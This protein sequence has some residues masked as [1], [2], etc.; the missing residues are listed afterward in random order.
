MPKP[1]S[2]VCHA[3]RSHLAVTRASYVWISEDA[4]SDTFTAFVHNHKRHGSNVPG[5]LEARKRAAKRRATQLAHQPATNYNPES[6]GVFDTRSQ[7]GWWQKGEKPVEPQATSWS[8]PFIFP[9]VARGPPPPPGPMLREDT[10]ETFEAQHG[11]SN[12]VDVEAKLQSHLRSVCTHAA[13]MDTLFNLS[14][15]VR[16]NPQF[17]NIILNHMIAQHWEHDEIAEFLIDPRTNPPGTTNHIY[18]LEHAKEHIELVRWLLRENVFAK[19]ARLGLLDITEIQQMLLLMPKLDISAF[20][21]SLTWAS[22]CWRLVDAMDESMVLTVHD[23]DTS[24]IASWLETMRSYSFC[25]AVPSLQWRL[26]RLLDSKVDKALA[27]VAY[28]S[29]SMVKE[30][31]IH[32]LESLVEFM[33]SQPHEHVG[34]AIFSL[35]HK[36][37][38]EAGLDKPESLSTS[39]LE[40]HVD[41]LFRKDLLRQVRGAYDFVSL[42]VDG[43]MADELSSL[44]AQLGASGVSEG[45]SEQS[46]AVQ[47]MLHQRLADV[48]KLELWYAVLGNLGFTPKMQFTMDE[49][50]FKDFLQTQMEGTDARQRLL[51]ALWVT[52]VLS[53]HDDA[54]FKSTG[55]PRTIALELQRTFSMA[56]A[57]QK[58]D[59]LANIC[60]TLRLYPLPAKNKL[61]RRLY[62]LSEETVSVRENYWD[63]SLRLNGLNNARVLELGNAVAYR[64]IKQHFPAKLAEIAEAFNTDIVKF[65]KSSIDIIRH[66]Q[67][68]INIVL[69]ILDHN[70]ELQKALRKAGKMMHSSRGSWDNTR[71]A[72]QPAFGGRSFLGLVE[73]IENFAYEIARTDKLSRRN[74]LRKV[75]WIGDYL[76]RCK[77][78]VRPPLRRALWYAGVTRYDEERDGSCY[79]H[80]RWLYDMIAEHDGEAEANRL[81]HISGMSGIETSRNESKKE[82][83]KLYR[84]YQQEAVEDVDGVEGA[85]NQVEKGSDKGRRR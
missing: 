18:V 4:L 53:I 62:A 71:Q 16:H 48:S 21:K 64:S 24:F 75:L 58:E 60:E 14:I 35:T 72:S 83:K 32:H 34:T 45:T 12:I 59:V 31:T 20:P 33:V 44:H 17:A 80:V 3:S 74:A 29:I 51:T 70:Q 63:L 9:Q 15:S 46:P 19:A 50:A 67:G 78:P 55:V 42:N 54:S 84:Q 79:Y 30:N 77:A 52:M 6:F 13:A 82:I 36:F 1:I 49:S 25:S 57:Q 43:D 28:T 2:T 73:M 66:A 69:R 47:R 40:Q 8:W 37:L 76:V 81:L 5:P 22:F 41:A 7:Q 85:E 65:E 26:H 10:L 39:S 61:L 23:L 11:E 27:E 68:S 38:D 56:G